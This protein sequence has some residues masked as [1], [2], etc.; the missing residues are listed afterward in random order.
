MT[1]GHSG[2]TRR[3]IDYLLRAV[4]IAALVLL[5]AGRSHAA[6]ITFTADL[7]PESAGATG[8]GF[9]TVVYDSTLHTLSIDATFSGLSGD[10]TVAHIHCGTAVSETGTVGV[11]VTPGTLPRFPGGVTAGSY[12]SPFL[13]DL[14]TSATYTAGFV[15]NFAGGSIAGAEAALLAGMYAGKAYFNVHSLTYPGG[16]IRGFLETQAVQT[17]EPASLLLLGTGLTT[18]ALR[19]RRR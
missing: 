16:E 19:R 1:V 3:S 14:T 4:A 10:T 11:A 12:T 9:V 7:G 5:S 8:T 18:L 17:P 2:A 6:M 15:N 13:L